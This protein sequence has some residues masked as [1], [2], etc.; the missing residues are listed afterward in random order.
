MSTS[1]ARLAGSA[2][3]YGAA[4]SYSTVPDNAEEIRRY[5]QHLRQLSETAVVPGPVVDPISSGLW[6]PPPTPI[7]SGRPTPD[8][9]RQRTLIRR[10]QR[11]VDEPSGITG[12][13]SISSARSESGAAQTVT[14]KIKDFRSASPLHLQAIDVDLELI[15]AKTIQIVQSPKGD[16]FIA[17]P[18]TE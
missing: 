17:I 2:G 3:T 5:L 9:G 6:V 11:T 4:E 15:E 16:R 12:I 8:D 14:R 13:R 1:E 7:S 10:N 18:L